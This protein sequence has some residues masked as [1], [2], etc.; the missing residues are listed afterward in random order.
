MYTNFLQYDLKYAL[1][2][3]CMGLP[4]SRIKGDAVQ[5]IYA[6]I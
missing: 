2:V 6:S 4:S 1:A 5:Y 3:V